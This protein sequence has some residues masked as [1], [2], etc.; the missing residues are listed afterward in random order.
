MLVIRIISRING[1]EVELIANPGG[2]AREQQIELVRELNAISID[3]FNK[4]TPPE[5]TWERTVRV[6]RIYLLKDSGRIVGYA[7]NALME[8]N[9]I[10]VNY[11][12]SALLRREVQNKGLYG[13]LN[14]LRVET[15][16]SDVI[17]TRT[18]NP[19]VVKGFLSLCEQL[20]MQGFPNGISPT[21]R[22]MDIAR[23]YSPNVD[24]DMVCK[25]VYGRALMDNTPNP[26]KSIEHICSKLDVDRGDGLILIGV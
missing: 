14:R 8:L 3:A 12:S 7:T 18:Q 20:G 19:L 24:P 21:E 2:L 4:P 5:E 22:V 9:G 16:D 26:C 13:P 6:G 10:G 15:I 23:A 17:M 11:F 25:G 1:F